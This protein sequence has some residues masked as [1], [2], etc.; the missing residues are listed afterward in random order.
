L[1][2]LASVLI[3]VL[4]AMCAS[5]SYAQI[6]NIFVAKKVDY[7]QTSATAIGNASYAFRGGVEGQGLAGLAPTLTGPINYA[8]LGAPYPT[9]GAM[10]Y[11]N[12]SWYFAPQG[13]QEWRYGSQAQ[14]DAAFGSGTYTITVNG[15]AIPLNLSGDAYPNPPRV[16]LSGGAWSNGKYVLDPSKEL[17]VTTDPFTGFTSHLNGVIGLAYG[18]FSHQLLQWA[19]PPPA[20]ANFATFTIPANTFPPNADQPIYVSFTSFVDNSGGQQR[21]GAPNTAWYQAINGITISTSTASGPGPTAPVSV[22]SLRKRLKYVQTSATDIAPDAGN[23]AVFHADVDGTGLDGIAAPTITGP[24]NVAAIGPA[25]NGGVLTYNAA[26]GGWRYGA[27][28]HDFGT[29]SV[30]QLG[31]LFPDGTYT[32]NVSGASVPLKLTGNAYPQPAAATLSGGAWSDGTYVIPRDQALS[33]DTGAFAGYG[34]HVNDTICVF[35]SGPG[36]VDD[37]RILTS[38]PGALQQASATPG[39]NSLSYTFPANTLASGQ[40]YMLNVVFNAIVDNESVSALPGSTNTAGYAAKMRIPLKA[41]EPVFPMTVT[42]D[43][44][45]TVSSASAQIQVRPQ[46]VGTQGSIYVFAVAPASIVKDAFAATRVPGDPFASYEWTST[47]DKDGLTVQCVLAQLSASGQLVGV[48]ASTL[49]AYVTG[50]LSSQG[51]AVTILNG[52]PTVN[53]GGATFYVGYGTSAQSMQ[54]GGTNRAALTV[55]GAQVCQPAA[56]QTGWWWNPLEDGRG[57]SVEVQG[58]HLFFASF[59]YDAS[60]RST[61]YVASGAA[62]LD[63]TLFTDVLYSA[64]N[65]QA[66]GAAYA[67]FP[68]LSNEG[69]ITLTFNSATNGTLVWPGGAVPIQRFNM[70]PN[71]LSMPKAANAPEGGWWWNAAESGRGFFMEWQGNTLDIAGYV[72]DDQGNPIWVL[73]Y[74]TTDDAGAVGKTLGGSWWTYAGGQ[75]LTGAYKPNHQVTNN[76]APVTVQFTGPATAVMTLPNGRSTTL[77]RQAF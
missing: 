17:T 24:F 59:L 72:Y 69:P 22:V 13:S 45:P 14:L 33:V 39:N 48:S 74:L 43:I 49:Q 76:F 4:G 7:N 66:L 1:K 11:S 60:G 58:N 40:Q 77:T 57:F 70:V 68:Q 64:K 42:A 50:T 46:D 65:G 31:S 6:Q 62:S 26:D 19:N 44:K 20:P 52:V 21:V 35:L 71:G 75:T 5:E 12:P 28:G 54:N 3:A 36:F 8:A 47:C 56:P 38:C 51:A 73:T 15:T 9:T 63:G 67:G 16:T 41:T 27:S 30:Q 61:W 37:S 34:S 10:T 55:P 23:N 25:H 32:L 29:S 18:D 53:I 2:L